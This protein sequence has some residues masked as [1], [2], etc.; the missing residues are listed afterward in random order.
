MCPVVKG[1]RALR[2]LFDR[3][4]KGALECIMD[5]SIGYCRVRIGRVRAEFQAR[6]SQQA[7][8][9]GGH[10]WA[11]D[12][13][14]L[15]TGVFRPISEDE[16]CQA[17][18]KLPGATAVGLDGITARSLKG[19]G[20]GLLARVYSL[21]YYLG[22]VPGEYK[23][24]RTV[25]VPKGGANLT[26]GLGGFRPISVSSC[27]YRAFSSII[28]SRL[29]S[30]VRLDRSQ[31]GFLRGESGL[32]INSYLLRACLRNAR[33]G[34]RPILICF[35]DLCKAFDTV[36][37]ASIY[38]ALVMQGVD[39]RMGR[40]VRS[41]LE[42]S[43]TE[44]W[45]GGESTGEIAVLRGVKQGDPISPL[46]FNLVL[47]ELLVKLNQAGLGYRYRRGDEVVDRVGVLAYADDLVLCGEGPVEIN[48]MLGICQSFFRE[49]GLKLN[50]KKCGLLWQD[51]VPSSRELFWRS[52]NEEVFIE[53]GGR[54]EYL[55]IVGSGDYK[56]LG[57]RVYLEGEGDP[58]GYVEGYLNK[59][60][61][62]KLKPQQKIAAV[63]VQLLGA[64]KHQVGVMSPGSGVV[65]ALDQMI[66]AF[67]KETLKVPAPY[68]CNSFIYLPLRRGGLGITN[69]REFVCIRKLFI[70]NKVVVSG[71]KVLL[72]LG[73]EG[74]YSRDLEKA[75]ALLGVSVQERFP[76][77]K[78]RG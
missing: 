29:G 21:W 67:I 26:D 35:L 42:G 49:H 39:Y 8:V 46:L 72:A 63:R 31:R 5:P 43:T 40:M 65:D 19:V 69:L 27:V 73:Q 50:V 2:A 11:E 53:A 18:R 68:I 62:C 30:G 4:A 55:P 6:F 57:H 77:N 1:V 61:V 45:Y 32:E 58:R 16:V 78:V 64:L 17:L 36:G 51:V 70:H 33:S 60:R 25:L 74:W 41:M 22:R 7:T 54:R 28:T 75:R 12:L 23:R 76:V 10:D 24:S 71:S 37:H 34:R 44:V 56:Y 38:R 48:R 59:L 52:K 3:Q 20:A 9:C 14:S 66:R 47:D 13:E 15:A